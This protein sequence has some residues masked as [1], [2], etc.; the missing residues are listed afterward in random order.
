[1]KEY[2]DVKTR[3][4]HGCRG[5]LDNATGQAD[6][7]TC[8][9]C[10]D[11]WTPEL[12]DWL[13]SPSQAEALAILVH[14]TERRGRYACWPTNKNDAEVGAVATGSVGVL[15]ASELAKPGNA[16]YWMATDLGI[17]VHQARAA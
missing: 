12:V 11:E 17:A 1:M 10:G 5:D 9:V 4:P 8:T 13:L 16:G 6:F 7:V 2:R 14:Q 3:C 15:A